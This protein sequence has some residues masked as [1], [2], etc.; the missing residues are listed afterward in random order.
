MNNQGHSFL[1]GGRLMKKTVYI[2]SLPWIIF[3][4]F[5]WAFSQDVYTGLISKL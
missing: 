1:K 2:L 5:G 3:F 4:A